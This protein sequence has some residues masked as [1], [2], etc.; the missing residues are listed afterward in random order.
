MK[1]KLLSLGMSVLVA[2]SALNASAELQMTASYKVG[3]SMGASGITGRQL[4][5]YDDENRLIRGVSI[6]TDYNGDS[7]PE[8]MNYYDY[9]ENGYLINSYNYQYRAA[10]GDWEGPKD[11]MVYT[12]DEQ[13]RLIKKEDP[14]RGTSYQYDEQ[15]RMTYEDYYPIN[16]AS[17]VT[18]I[19]Q[20]NYSDFDENGNPTTYTG[21]GMN[22]SYRFDG[23]IEYDAQGRRLVCKQYDILS[24]AKK[25]RIEYTYDEL[26]VCTLEL[27][28]KAGSTKTDTVVAGSEADT[29]MFNK[30]IV[31]EANGNGWYARQDWTYSKITYTKPYEYKWTKNGTSY[32]EL[33]VDVQGEYAPTNLAVENISTTERPQTI[34]V[35][36]DAPATLPCEEVS[37]RIWRG[38]VVVGTATAVDGKVEFIDEGMTVGTYE[39]WV[40][41]YDATN[42]VYYNTSDIVAV[43]VTVPLSPATNVRITGGYHG[44]Y[45]DPQVGSYESFFI[46]LAWDVE[47]CD[48]T[49]LGY[50]VWVYPW[51]YAFLEIEGD[52]KSCEL[53][54]T[55]DRCADIRVDVVY[56][57]GTKEG[58]YTTLFWDN[59]ADF[60]GEPLPKYYLTHEVKYGDHMGSSSSATGINYYIYDA[61]NNLSRRIDY[62]YNTDGS[63]SPLYHYFYDYNE[64][65]QIISE[66][67]RQMNAMGEWGKNKM[68]YVYTYDEQGRLAAKEDTTSNRIYEYTYDLVGRIA[69]MTDKGKTWGSDTYDKLY[70]T[71]YYYDYN[72][73]GHAT[74]VE[75]VH[76]MYASSSYNTTNTYD[77]QGRLLVAESRTPEGMAY[78][79][80]EYTYDKYGVITSMT[81]SKPYYDPATY[82]ATENFEYSTRTIREAQGNSVYK[83]YDENY[84]AKTGEWTLSGNRYTMETYSPLN[85]SLSP[86]NLILT[87]VSTP[88]QPNTIEV[89]CNF[90]SVKLADAQYIIWRGW[91]PVDT[92]T[93]TAAQGVIRYTDVDIENGTYEYFVQTYNA[94]TGQSFN[95]TAPASFTLAVELAQATNLRRTGQTEGVYRDPEVGELPAYWVHFAWDA[96]QT[97]LEVLGYNIYQDNYK[98]PVS[99]TTNLN[100]SV[101]VYRDSEE[102]IEEQQISTAVAIGVIY[103]FGESEW[104]DAVF[105]IEIS[106]L[107]NV[108][109]EG[110]AYVA[111]KTL[112]V[113]PQSEVT[114][115]NVAGS[116]VATYNNNT[117]IDLANMPGGVYVAVVKVGNNNQVLKLAL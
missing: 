64:N 100:D 8:T 90:P 61:N 95:A 114:I 39:Y 34:K 15:G 13:G 37:Y 43:D 83:K 24:G 18:M 29:L 68:T 11:N 42:D 3:D 89:E 17:G 27:H 115:Y 51:A 25:A 102:N 44:T 1:K 54:M 53:S 21:D 69:S 9:D 107:E 16:S 32:N 41:T 12:Y 57:L 45:N 82:Q 73:F 7:Y 105:E 88:E 86:Q 104:T 99:T 106:A 31:R 96:P 98:V 78:E 77:E 87:D 2:A 67:Y 71:T 56:D 70:S 74:R 4:N 97:S 26:G 93:A 5:Y 108:T 33:Y 38:G 81:L 109:L 116:A 6:A 92:V 48:A 85:G 65:G 117:A 23:T 112:F 28:Y 75:Y 50:K 72:E 52:T 79:K 20:I 80:S 113:E 55:D 46:K 10:Y 63:T 14:T 110:S 111:G 59:S 35:T 19:S 36:F 40:Q 66:F 91:I 58:G 49:I 22:S 47:P 30:K 60:E 101:W 62:G 84:S 103:G 94:A 76:A